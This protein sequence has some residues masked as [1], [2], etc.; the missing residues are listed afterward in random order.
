M[1]V[2]LAVTLVGAVGGG[3]GTAQAE[4]SGSGASYDRQLLFYNHS[5]GVL[6][7]ETA[8]AIERSD[9]LKDFASFEVRTTTGSGGQTWTGRYL[10][11]RETYLE[12]FG[13]GDLPGPD[14][15]LGAAGLGVSTERDGDLATVAERMKSEGATPIE[16]LQTRD[17]GDGVPVPWFDALLTATEYDAFQAWAMEYRPEYFADPRS[18]TEPASFP[19]DVGRERY[20]SDDYRNHLMRDITSVHLAVTE[21]DLADTVPLL[22][23]GGFAVRTVTGGGVVAEGGGTTIRLDAV[24]RAQAGLQ[25]VTMSLNRPVKDRHVERI[26]NSTLTIGPGSH[27]VWTFP[28]NGTP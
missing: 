9:Y 5:Y 4:G 14:G 6:D 15:T 7:R 3:V 21:G 16:F 10:R 8:D 26:G 28:A 23:A 24:P 20:L 25:R 11:G 12:L 22:R 2:V 17:F 1:I 13:V 19:G 27:A 18:N